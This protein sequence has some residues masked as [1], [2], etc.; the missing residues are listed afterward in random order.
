MHG[1]HSH[2]GLGCFGGKAAVRALSKGPN[3]ICDDAGGQKKRNNLRSKMHELSLIIACYNEMT[4]GLIFRLGPLGAHF[5]CQADS[6]G[7]IAAADGGALIPP[8][9]KIII[10][11][12]G[13]LRL[14]AQGRGVAVANRRFAAF[15]MKPLD[16]GD[17]T[18]HAAA[19]MLNN[20]NQKPRNGFRV[21]NRLSDRFPFD[22]TPIPRLP[23]RTAEMSG[24]GFVRIIG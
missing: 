20:R 17:W 23:G 8:G 5:C 14:L 16:R 7:R 1:T 11:G 2:D 15:R 6:Q 22:L 9:I 21:G 12:I 13:N 3:R 4:S 18:H 24:E 10:G 19:L